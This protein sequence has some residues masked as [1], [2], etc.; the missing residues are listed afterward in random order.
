MN[1]GLKGLFEEAIFRLARVMRLGRWMLVDAYS[2]FCRAVGFLPLSYCLAV[3][4]GRL[5][6][7]LI[8]HYSSFG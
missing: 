4:Q 6:G 5:E 8:V 1:I 3:R 2:L 7:N